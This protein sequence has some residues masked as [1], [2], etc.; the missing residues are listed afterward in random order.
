[1]PNSQHWDSFIIGSPPPT[2]HADTGVFTGKFEE[3]GSDGGDFELADDSVSESK[4]EEK[5][6]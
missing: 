4:V 6:D 1:M 5:Q 2:P 3:V